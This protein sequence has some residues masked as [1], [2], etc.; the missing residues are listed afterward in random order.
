METK[1]FKINSLTQVFYGQDDT[2]ETDI[3]YL[4]PMDE[5]EVEP[6]SGGVGGHW[7]RVISVAS[8]SGNTGIN[9]FMD[10]HSEQPPFERSRQWQAPVH[11]KNLAVVLQGLRSGVRMH[12]IA[13]SNP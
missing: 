10:A 12:N 9:Y 13:T 11:K 7:Y 6:V 1:K 4:Y 8:I 2:K 3:P 5:V